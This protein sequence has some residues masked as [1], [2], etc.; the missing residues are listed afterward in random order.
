MPDAEVLHP[1]LMFGLFSE[2]W[3][4]RIALAGV[5]EHVDVDRLTPPRDAELEERLPPE[6]IAARFY[7]R[8]VTFNEMA[9]LA[10]ESAVLTAAVVFLL[11]VASVFQY[12]MGMS[13][14]PNLLADVLGPLKS[15]P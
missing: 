5:M 11:A 6:F 10:Y 9:K 8:N 14:V 7:Y 3:L 13:G 12:L 1:S 4:H 2:Y 15:M